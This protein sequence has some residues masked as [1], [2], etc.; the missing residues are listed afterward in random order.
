MT[1]TAYSNLKKALDEGKFVF[2]G[3]LEP[4]FSTSIDDVIGDANAMKDFV[5]AA[6]VTDN[7]ASDTGFVSIVASYLTQQ[8]TN[9]EMIWQLRCTDKNRMALVADLLAAPKLGLKNVLALTGDH[10]WCSPDWRVSKP[11]YD[12]DSSTLI[13]L[14]NEMVE[15]GTAFGKE[16]SGDRIQLNVGGA[17]NPNAGPLEAEILKLKRKAKAGCDW[18]QTQVVYDLQ[19]TL[20]FLKEVNKFGVPVLIGLFPM[21]SYEVARGFDAFVPGVSVPKDLLGKFKTVRTEWKNVDKAKMKEEYLRLNEEFLGP[22]INE[23]YTKKASAG[24]HIMAVHYPKA[25]APLLKYAK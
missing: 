24:I 1:T 2:T 3:E 18:F 7:P 19:A 12:L 22:F 6:N 11:V 21:K 13:R 16:Y 15:K 9:L 17:A 23:L 5:I 25:F 4:K 14:V 10:P 8:A 20:D